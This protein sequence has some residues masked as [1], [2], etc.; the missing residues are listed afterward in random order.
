MEMKTLQIFSQHVNFWN[1]WMLCIQEMTVFLNHVKLEKLTSHVGQEE[2]G[3]TVAILRKLCGL[4]FL[5]LLD[6]F[7]PNIYV[8]VSGSAG[9]I[10]F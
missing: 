3:V 5:A 9:N 2:E 4:H 7:F 8:G 10:A 6:M 1:T